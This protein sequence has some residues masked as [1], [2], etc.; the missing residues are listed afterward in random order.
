MIIEINGEEVVRNLELVTD[1]ARQLRFHNIGVSINDLGT[2]WPLLMGIRDFPF[3]EIKVDKQFVA[4][5]ADDRTK[6]TTC[7]RILN[8]AD[9][10]GSRTV[11]GGVE[12]RADFAVVREMGFNLVQSYL[13]ARPMA[14][15]KFA[16]TMLGRSLSFPR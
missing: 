1:V 12:S 16:R 3:V 5:C 11:A 9:G 4:G 15:K 2:E 10:Y 13:F 8:L 14:A 7:G 6:R